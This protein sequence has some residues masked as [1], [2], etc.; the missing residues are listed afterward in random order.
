MELIPSP[1]HMC[2]P[3]LCVDI[4][5][6]PNTH[7]PLTRIY[8]KLDKCLRPGR[9]TSCTLVQDCRLKSKYFLPRVAQ[10]LCPN[11]T[12]QKSTLKHLVQLLSSKTATGLPFIL[13]L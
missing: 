10:V 8:I 3:T 1:T 2:I 6:G 13:Y 12:I 9:F 5:N 11:T 7:E 4:I